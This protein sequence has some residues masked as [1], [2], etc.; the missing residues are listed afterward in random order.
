LELWWK[1]GRAWGTAGQGG[2]ATAR[3][4]GR[5]QDHRLLPDDQSGSLVN[6][7]GAQIGSCPAGKQAAAFRAAVIQS[8]VG[9]SGKGDSGCSRSHRE[10]TN[11][12]GYSGSK[13]V[14]VLLE[15]P[16]TLDVERLQGEEEEDKVEVKRGRPG[17]T[18]FTD[19]LRL[20]DGA[21]G[22]AVV[23]KSGQSWVSIE[24]YVGH[25]REAYDVECAVSA[26]SLETASRRQTI[27]DRVMILTDAQAAI[28]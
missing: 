13:E 6:R 17:L 21:T 19:G 14:T 27:P 2:A 1:G 15:E 24:T 22:Y 20:D 23:W 28:K 3:Q 25:N 11:S 7:I 18:M 10:L 26:R 12:L 8:A 4:P 9:R 5:T 16:E